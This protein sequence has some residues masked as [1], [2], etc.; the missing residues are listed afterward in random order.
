MDNPQIHPVAKGITNHFASDGGRV[1]RA[2]F[3]CDP[4]MTLLDHF[5]GQ[6]MIGLIEGYDHEARMYSANKNDR[7][8]FDDNPH[9]EDGKSFAGLLAEEAYTIAEAMLIERERRLKRK[10][11]PSESA[12]PPA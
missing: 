7:T 9:G 2:D 11:K 12:N 6:A 5:A 3:H 4:G 8:G 10:E 1:I